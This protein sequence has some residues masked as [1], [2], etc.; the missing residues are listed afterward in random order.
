MKYVANPV[1]VTAFKITDIGKC[2]V[3]NCEIKH[4][5]VILLENGQPKIVSHDMLCRFD[6]QVGD[7]WVQQEDGY[8]YLNPKEVFERKYSKVE[9]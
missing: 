7:Y 9:E 4:N 5:K 1:I 8:V 3:D 2:Q 6:L